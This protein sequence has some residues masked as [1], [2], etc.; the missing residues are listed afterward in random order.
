MERPRENSPDLS[1]PTGDH[2]S[3][4]DKVPNRSRLAHGD[5]MPQPEHLFAANKEYAMPSSPRAKAHEDKRRGKSAS[6]QAGELVR[7]EIHR[8]RS[9]E[10]GARSAKQ[11]IAIG[12]SQAR[13]AGVDLPPPK[14]GKTSKKTR[15]SAK[16]AYDAGHGHQHGTSSPR[17]SRAIMKALKR[18]GHAA[19]STRALSRQA[20]SSAS[21]RTASDRSAAAR[22]A[23]A[24]KGHRGEG[25]RHARRPELGLATCNGDTS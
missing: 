18:E 24:T 19:A 9:G 5:L 16:A 20:R 11:A 4:P 23:A 14:A 15:R 12:L 13:R 1:R 6:T 2:D 7:D 3:H 10:H 22:K 25:P 21:R 17:L 8:I